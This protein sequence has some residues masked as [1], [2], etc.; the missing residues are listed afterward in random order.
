[1]LKISLKFCYNLSLIGIFFTL[2]SPASYADPI[3][4]TLRNP[5]NIT[6]TNEIIRINT[7]LLKKK[8]PD[9]NFNSFS[10]F[11]NDDEIPYDL[12]YTESMDSHDVLVLLDFKPDETKK[13]VFVDKAAGNKAE[14]ETQAYLGQKVDYILKEGYYIEGHFESVDSAKVPLTHFAHDALYQFEGPGWES[15]KIAYRLYLDDRNR[16]D[17]FGKKEKGLFLDIT[18][19]NDLVSDGN[20]SYQSMLDW[21]RDILK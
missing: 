12:V 8:N 4:V 9:F 5:L 10:V 21:G 19:K 17:I 16:T 1:M 18:G 3:A 11:D 6:R 20:E 14:K 15:E 7:E 13:I 2:T